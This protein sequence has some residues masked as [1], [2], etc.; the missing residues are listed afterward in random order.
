M[1]HIA[2]GVRCNRDSDTFLNVQ[3]LIAFYAIM[4]HITVNQTPNHADYRLLNEIV[5]WRFLNNIKSKY[6]YLRGLVFVWDTPRS[7]QYSR[8]E[9]IAGESKISNKKC[10]VL[11]SRINFIISYT[12]TNYSYDRFYNLHSYLPSLRFM[13]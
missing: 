6:I 8:E 5:R 9:R 4:S 7:R 11:L 13:L 3:Q 2:Y 10:F 12:V 1:R